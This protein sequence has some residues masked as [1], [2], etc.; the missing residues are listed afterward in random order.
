[1]VLIRDRA[2]LAMMIGQTLIWAA[3]FYSF[4]I[5]VPT[6]EAAFGWSNPAIMAAFSLAAV[7]WAL[8]TPYAGRAIDRGWGSLLLPGAGFCGAVLLVLLSRVESYGAFLA[9]WA[10]MGFFMASHA[11]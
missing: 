2:I 7:I 3:L 10:A 9:I 4:V 1:M 6:W 8:A 5:L 11:L